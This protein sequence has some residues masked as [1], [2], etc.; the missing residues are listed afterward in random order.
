LNIEWEYVKDDF[1]GKIII[2]LKTKP[3]NNY[4]YPKTLELWPK[5][6]IGN[7]I[8]NAR[9]FEISRILGEKWDFVIGYNRKKSIIDQKPFFEAVNARI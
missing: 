9:F 3:T 6:Y 5:G 2:I 4:D 8:M 7:S 1:I